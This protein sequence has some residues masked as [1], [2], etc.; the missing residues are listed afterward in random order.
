MRRK[1][2]RSVLPDGAKIDSLRKERGWTIEEFAEEGAEFSSRTAQ[3]AIAGKGVDVTTLSAIAKR[4][5]VPYDSLLLKPTG[6]PA[7]TVSG[8]AS[9]TEA[10]YLI[11]KVPC[12]ISGAGN[13]FSQIP[14]ILKK[15]SE[16]LPEGID[17]TF[18]GTTGMSVLV[19]IAFTPSN[20]LALSE[21][22][23]ELGIEEVRATDRRTV[24]NS[25]FV[26]GTVGR[27]AQWIRSGM[28]GE[29]PIAYS[30]IGGY[31]LDRVVRGRGRFLLD[32]ESDTEGGEIP[33]ESVARFLELVL[34]DNQSVSAV[35]ERNNDEFRFAVPMTSR[36]ELLL[37]VM[38]FA[39]KKRVMAKPR[40][41]HYEY[42]S[43]HRNPNIYN[44]DD[45]TI[46]YVADG[47][48]AQR[49]RDDGSF[50]WLWLC[51]MLG[52]RDDDGDALLEALRT[53]TEAI[54]EYVDEANAAQG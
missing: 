17:I 44:L 26:R 13:A 3:T 52:L 47:G 35:G 9:S 5:G 27:I 2:A 11:L 12:A 21:I 8:S 10:G 15:I 51:L 31:A 41:L 4:L 50:D 24:E 48:V 54:L 40:I 43:N 30:P 45:R 7:D 38:G 25:P 19:A 20:A 22:S 23:D 39:M 29:N 1:G 34:P 46:S 53:I 28:R 49:M 42:D 18:L 37:A 16:G 33:V 32:V 6:S 36:N 14:D